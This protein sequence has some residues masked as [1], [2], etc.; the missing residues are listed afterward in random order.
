MLNTSSET[1]KRARKLSSHVRL[2]TVTSAF[3][4]VVI[5]GTA[6]WSWWTHG[7]VRTLAEAGTASNDAALAALRAAVEGWGAIAPLAYVAAVVVEVTVAP[8]P[9]TLLYAPAGAIWGGFF[10]GLLSLAGNTIG[11]MVAC[12]I[13]R[14]LGEAVIARR[15]AGSRVAPYIE[16][17]RA[18]GFWVVLLLRI[19]PLTSSDL[20]SYA[21][22][23]IGVPV[24]RVGLATFIG[25]AP[26][27]FA[28][29]YLAEQIFQILPGAV[30]VLAAAG[31]AYVGILA[32]WLIGRQGS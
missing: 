16:R 6:T 15:M 8:I 4:L 13:A 5:V 24:W 25:M 28:Q 27:C 17:L 7:V 30:Y 19:N 2:R 29:A 12:G 1:E 9:G 20:V 10:G 31:L 18:R 23:A 26:L 32:W 11:A 14:G 3:A 22:G 21:A